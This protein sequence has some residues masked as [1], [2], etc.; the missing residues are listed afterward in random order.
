MEKKTVRLLDDVDVRVVEGVL[1]AP[2]SRT[3][4]FVGSLP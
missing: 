1:V 3:Y 2:E 4:L